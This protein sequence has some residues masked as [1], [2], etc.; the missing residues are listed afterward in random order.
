[1]ETEVEKTVLEKDSVSHPTPIAF[2]LGPSRGYLAS[3]EKKPSDLKQAHNAA[4][5]YLKRR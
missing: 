3:C 4:L 5:R 2:M 1:M